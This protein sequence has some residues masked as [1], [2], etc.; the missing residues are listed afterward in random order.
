MPCPEDL[1]D[2]GIKLGSPALQVDSLP[3]ELPDLPRSPCSHLYSS[4]IFTSFFS[5]Y[6]QTTNSICLLRFQHHIQQTVHSSKFCGRKYKS[7]PWSFPQ[8]HPC[9][10][11]QE[12]SWGST[13]KSGELR[14]CEQLSST[15]TERRSTGF[16]ERP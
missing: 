10:D 15:E 5:M 16:L 1:P 14:S 6:P 3:A 13:H 7:P 11:R 12:G 4:F 2:P 8:Y 9:F